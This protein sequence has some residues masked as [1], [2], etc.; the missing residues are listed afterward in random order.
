MYYS[1]EEISVA[2]DKATTI[3]NNRTKY[4]GFQR[5][6]SDCYAFLVEYD[7]VLRGTT[8]AY[9]IFNF[10]YKNAKEFFIK[11]YR[12]GYDLKSFATYCGYE[13]QSKPRPMFGDITFINGSAMIAGK[14]RWVTVEENGGISISRQYRH[15]EKDLLLLARPLRS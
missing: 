5:G 6:F 1:V 9:D 10:E 4:E 15:F 13:L 2:L 3:I 14:Y 11:L 12:K 7:R 8:K